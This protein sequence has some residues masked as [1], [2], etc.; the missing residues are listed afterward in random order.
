MS[1]P[2]R[3]EPDPNASSLIAS[4]PIV[5]TPSAEETPGDDVLLSWSV[6]HLSRDPRR[7]WGAAAAVSIAACA[8]LFF[9]HSIVFALAG[10]ILILLSAA[11]FVFPVRHELTNLHARYGFGLTRYEIAWKDVLRVIP[12]P[13]GVKLS[14]L[15][16]PSRLDAFR[17]VTL[18]FAGDGQPG[19]RA[20]VMSFVEARMPSRVQEATYTGGGEVAE[21]HGPVLSGASLPQVAQRV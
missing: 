7:A 4:N 6:H 13:G 15:A 12:L 16:E 10:A 14:P 20:S 17:G 21:G 1:A 2:P 9:F 5:S 18:Q 8:G 3:D 19:D 11:E